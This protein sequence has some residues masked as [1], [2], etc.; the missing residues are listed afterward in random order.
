MPA[1]YID[2]P[3]IV[4][5]MELMSANANRVFLQVSTI[6]GESSLLLVGDTLETGILIPVVFGPSP[7]LLYNV[8][9]SAMQGRVSVFFAFTTHFLSV[10]E[11][12]RT[13]GGIT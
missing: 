10:M 12:F 8:H 11:I 13:P 5:G 3:G 2:V 1:N 9:G 6:S 7:P 4:A